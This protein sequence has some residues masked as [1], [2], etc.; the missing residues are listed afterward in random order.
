MSARDFQRSHPESETG[1]QTPGGHHQKLRGQ[2]NA[3]IN[4]Y[5]GANPNRRWEGFIKYKSVLMADE[6]DWFDHG[7]QS[8]PA[9]QSGNFAGHYLQFRAR[10]WI[11]PKSVCFDFMSRSLHQVSM[12]LS[13]RTIDYRASSNWHA[14]DTQTLQLNDFACQFMITK[15][16]K[17]AV[18]ITKVIRRF[19]LDPTHNRG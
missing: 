17:C 9:G 6:N 11:G 3:V 2:I 10:Y 18:F 12:D 7:R 16:K 8:D 1:D 13:D 4:R 15:D 5:A 14:A 19:R